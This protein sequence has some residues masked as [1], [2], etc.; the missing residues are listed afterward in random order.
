MIPALC[1]DDGKRLGGLR[2]AE[3]LSPKRRAEISSAAAKARWL[4]ERAP[5]TVWSVYALTD[6]NSED[7]FYIGCSMN[8]AS[9]R[10]RH[11]N[12]GASAAYGRTFELRVLSEHEDK[13]EARR[14]EGRLITTLPGLVNRQPSH[15]RPWGDPDPTLRSVRM[16]A[17]LWAFVADRAKAR[18]VSVN[19]WMIR[20]VEDARKRL[21]APPP[22]PSPTDATGIPVE[23]RLS[24]MSTTPRPKGTKK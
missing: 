9:T 10:S 17:D 14:E 11:K 8:L 13:Y 3:V 1:M 19:A 2:R 4:A 6:P 7:P 15:G 24:G 22:P 23:K 5:G 12:D 21:E 18:G 16:S 20:C